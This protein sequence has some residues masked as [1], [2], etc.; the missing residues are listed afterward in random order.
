MKKEGL[1][2]SFVSVGGSYKHL[3]SKVTKRDAVQA[4]LVIVRGSKTPNAPITKIGHTYSAA[5]NMR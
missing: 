3:A 1:Y 4:L 2:S 5:V